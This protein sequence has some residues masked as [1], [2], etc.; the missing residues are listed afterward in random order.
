M[1]IPFQYHIY[2]NGRRLIPISRI[3]SKGTFWIWVQNIYQCFQIFE[4]FSTL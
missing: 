2:P 4:A 3:K 1:G